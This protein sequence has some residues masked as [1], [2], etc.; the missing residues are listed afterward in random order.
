[1]AATAI[2]TIRAGGVLQIIGA[3]NGVGD[4]LAYVLGF[5]ETG[6]PFTFQ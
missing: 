5:L 6:G 1:M 4:T 3:Y 2:R